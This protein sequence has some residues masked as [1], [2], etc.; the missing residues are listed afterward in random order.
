MR[1]CRE[2]KAVVPEDY[3]WS[4]VL[5]ALKDDGMYTQ[6]DINTL[7]EGKPVYMQT[8]DEGS[9]IASFSLSTR[10]VPLGLQESA[11]NAFGDS[12]THYLLG[13]WQMLKGPDLGDD[14]NIMKAYL[15]GCLDTGTLTQYQVDMLLAVGKC[16]QHDAPNK[17]TNYFIEGR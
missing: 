8:I 17:T 15:R 2:T 12:A 4:A 10:I 1:F 9:V 6:E 5:Q 14:W 16:K 13:F 11:P 3:M 7:S